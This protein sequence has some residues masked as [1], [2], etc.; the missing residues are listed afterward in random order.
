MS[1]LTESLLPNLRGSACGC[2]CAILNALVCQGSDTNHDKNIKITQRVAYCKFWVS[3]SCGKRVA[4]TLWA[5]KCKNRKSAK[6]SMTG[7]PS[8]FRDAVG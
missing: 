6:P 8:V 7:A 5:G 2:P 1:A 4:G 3:S